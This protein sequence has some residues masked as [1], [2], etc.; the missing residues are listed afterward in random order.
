LVGVPSQVSSYNRA[1]ASLSVLHR[2]PTR[3]HR[4]GCDSIGRARF[5]RLLAPSWELCFACVGVGVGVAARVGR[6]QARRTRTSSM[7]RPPKASGTCRRAAAVV[8]AAAAL[9]I[10]YSAVSYIAACRSQP[11]VG[12][13]DRA[14]RPGRGIDHRPAA[15]AWCRLRIAAAS[16]R[17][18]SHRIASHRIACRSLSAAAVARRSLRGARSTLPALLGVRGVFALRRLV[19]VL[20]FRLS[21]RGVVGFSRSPVRPKLSAAQ[22]Q[23]QRPHGPRCGLVRVLTGSRV[24]VRVG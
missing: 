2:A 10:A 23:A 8:S 5:A 15:A 11:N 14:A 7:T 12:A 19:Q 6:P 21:T 22:Q 18:A 16:H 13:A 3:P 24:R 9:P 4:H 20:S 1:A 17:I